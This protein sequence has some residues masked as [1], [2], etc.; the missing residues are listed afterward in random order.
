MEE[1][2]LKHWQDIDRVELALRLRRLIKFPGGYHRVLWEELVK[3]LEDPKLDALT[4]AEA[5]KVMNIHD[6]RGTVS[7]VANKVRREVKKASKELVDDPTQDPQIY[8]S[9]KAFAICARKDAPKEWAKI[10][11][12][13]IGLLLAD[14]EDVFVGSLIRGVSE[15]CS[16]HRYDLVVDVSHED[17]HIEVSKLQHMLRR[18]SGALIVP[19]GEKMQR[20]FTQLVQK[21]PCVLIDRYRPFVP[22]VPCVHLD[23]I[24]AG[25]KAA[26]YLQELGCSRVLVVDQGSRSSTRF[27]ITPLQDRCDGCKL[28]LENSGIKVEHLL[29]AGSDEDGGFQALEQFE[30]SKKGNLL[31][32]KDGDKDGIFALTDKLALGCLHYLNSKQP[33]LKLPII[34]VEGQSFGNFVTP[35][36]ASIYFDMVDMGKRAAQVLFARLGKTE[37]PPTDCPPHFLMTPTLLKPSSV[38]GKRREEDTSAFSDAASHYS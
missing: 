32:D 8:V 22:D 15:I 21:N 11:T 7:V 5:A 19:V 4:V 30:K 36:F 27:D 14:A 16:K 1:D 12:P 24:S 28:Q 31:R 26:E 6:D 3:R 34:G 18:T 23:D 29:V 33:Q 37:M 25:R 13:S 35:P 38:P 9:R 20:G 10:V 2:R 17:S